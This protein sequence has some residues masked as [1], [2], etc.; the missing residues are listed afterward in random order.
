V[1]DRVAELR[2][3]GLRAEAHAADLSDADAVTGLAARIAAAHD[4]RIAAVA[5]VAG[6]FAW[7]GPIAGSDPAALAQQW[8]INASTAFST[9]RAFTP[10]VR[11][12]QGA[13]VFVS[14]PAA[15]PGG[16]RAGLSAYAMAKGAIA[17]L[18]ATLA[19][20]ERPHGVR[21]NAVAPTALRTAQNVQDMG[22]D[23]PY[24]E[25]EEFAAVLL[26]LCA[27]AWRRVTGQV[28]TLA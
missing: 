22:A 20:E 10:F 8:L 25:R 21:V 14:S 24:V 15:L 12:A 26:S 4:G 3:D 2:G 28:V 17:P 1:G 27:P 13:L 23:V 11:A 9:A 16:A 7:S 18:V 6:G 19:E 5:A